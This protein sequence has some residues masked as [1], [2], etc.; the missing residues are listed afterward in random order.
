MR[1]HAGLVEKK[2]FWSVRALVR[3]GSAAHLQASVVER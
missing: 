3:C 1:A 2:S